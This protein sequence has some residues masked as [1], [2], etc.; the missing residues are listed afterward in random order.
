MAAIGNLFRA[1][2]YRG[3]EGQ[4]AWMLHR[5]AGVGVFVFLAFH[6]LDIFLMAFG[7]EVFDTLLFFYHQFFFKLMIIFGLYLGVLYH[8]LNG[9]RVVIIDFW[10]G[11]AKYQAKLWRIQMVI[12]TLAYVPSAAI[13]LSQMFGGH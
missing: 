6:I 8:A 5:V 4:I 9:I 13:M 7:P 12:F 2:T 11:M 3:R 1:A 10:P